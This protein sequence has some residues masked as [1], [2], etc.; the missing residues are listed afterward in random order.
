MLVERSTNEKAV[1]GLVAKDMV[2]KKFKI[3]QENLDQL[4]SMIF[5]KS[6]SPLNEKGSHY[7]N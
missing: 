4:H 5:Q 1:E 7:V 2:N 3:L 6:L